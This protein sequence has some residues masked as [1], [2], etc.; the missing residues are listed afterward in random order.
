MR[1][2]LLLCF[3]IFMVGFIFAKEATPEKVSD[4]KLSSL[5]GEAVSLSYYIKDKDV[6]FI[7]FFTTWCPWCAKQL[8][9]FEEM[10]NSNSGNVQYLAIG[11]DNDPKKI[12]SKIKSLGVTYPALVG[13]DKIA[14]YFNI[15]GIPVTVVVDKKGNKIDQVVG[16]REKSYFLKYLPK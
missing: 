5:K 16:F 4:F 11:F 8:E 6:S 7:V 13:N 12:I 1:K 10:A 15:S 9:A 3:M 2:I 14:E